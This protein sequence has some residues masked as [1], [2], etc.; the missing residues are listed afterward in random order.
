[1]KIIY[2]KN[3]KKRFNKLSQKNQKLF[4][5]KVGIFMEDPNNSILRKHKLKGRLKN[6]SAFSI[7]N[8]CRVIFQVINDY[9]VL[10]I[11]IGTHNQ[12]Y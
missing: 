3:F 1:M 4:K 12:V 10:F 6:Y 5:T 2:T 8:D 11:D 7:N 9:S